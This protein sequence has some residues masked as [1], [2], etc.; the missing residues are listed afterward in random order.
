MSEQQDII[1]DDLASAMADTDPFDKTGLDDLTTAMNNTDPFGTKSAMSDRETNL[2]VSS[3]SG[4]KTT[5]IQS[6][7]TDHINTPLTAEDKEWLQANG[8]NGRYP[9]DASDDERLLIL[10]GVRDY[11][12]PRNGG[13]AIAA[14]AIDSRPP[15][16]GPLYHT[17]LSFPSRAEIVHRYGW[18]LRC[19]FHDLAETPCMPE[20]PIVYDA[21]CDFMAEEIYRRYMDLHIP[22]V[23]SPRNHKWYPCWTEHHVFNGTLKGIKSSQDM[24]QAIVIG[25]KDSG[26]GGGGEDLMDEGM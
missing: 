21:L 15:T 4:H 2:S 5:P 24:W 11:R 22:P 13:S 26:M 17:A 19:S 25:G 3:L 14:D 7:Q 18:M 9:P 16:P 20:H 23:Y 1:M 8:F 10:A 6:T 12:L